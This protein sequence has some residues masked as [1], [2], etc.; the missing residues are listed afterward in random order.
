[1]MR[2]SKPRVR[3]S[4]ILAGTVSILWSTVALVLLAALAI[5]LWLYF[6]GTNAIEEGMGAAL[7][8]GAL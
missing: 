8:S 5:G 3:E 7:G 2:R 4:R 6:P 1:M